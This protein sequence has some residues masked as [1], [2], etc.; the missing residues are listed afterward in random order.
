MRLINNIDFFQV[1]VVGGSSEYYFPQ[2]V[3]WAGKKINSLVVVGSNGQNEVS[4]IDGSTPLLTLN[5]LKDLYIDLVSAE[6]KELARNLHVDNVVYQNNYV[7]SVESVLSLNLCRFIFSDNYF[8]SG[9]FLVYVIY[10]SEETTENNPVNSVT[11]GLQLQ[12]NEEISIKEIID[13]YMHVKT[14]CVKGLISW[15]T[16]EPFYLTLRDENDTYTFNS[17]HSSLMRPQINKGSAQNTQIYPLL[18]N[19][20]DVDMDNSFIRNATNSTINV[21]LSFYY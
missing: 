1:N 19:N 16:E 17:V 12:A 4:P 6:D 21:T 2:N 15:N 11:V 5:E 14:E 13:E 7:Y 8:N 9:C 20:K 3:S 18:L 10:E